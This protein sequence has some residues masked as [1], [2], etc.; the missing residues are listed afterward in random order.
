MVELQRLCTPTIATSL[1]LSAQGL[2]R[3]APDLSA[4]TRHSPDQIVATVGIRPIVN[5]C[6]P[7]RLQPLALPLSYRGVSS[8]GDYRPAPLTVKHNLATRPLPLYHVS[9]M[10]RLLLALALSAATGCASTSTPRPAA[11]ECTMC[12]TH[13]DS[14]ATCCGAPA[15]PCRF[16]CPCGRH[17]DAPARCCGA[18]MPPASPA[19]CPACKKTGV[20]G[21]TCCGAR[22]K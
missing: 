10:T 15:R 4:A 3:P 2:Q 1:T 18:D 22:I 13:R 19:T 14:P 9:T 21:M 17:S 8:A 12:R 7:R 6:N 16:A 5:H 20:A 11:W